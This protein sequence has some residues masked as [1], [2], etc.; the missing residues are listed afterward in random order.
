MCV[1]SVLLPV[2]HGSDTPERPQVDD[3]G[4]SFVRDE[5]MICSIYTRTLG[6]Y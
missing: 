5:V 3:G 6:S 1:L 2:F 4:G